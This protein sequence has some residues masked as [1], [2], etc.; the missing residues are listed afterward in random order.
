[1]ASSGFYG[2]VYISRS[3]L[4]PDFLLL[5]V[6]RHFELLDYVDCVPTVWNMVMLSRS[7]TK[8]KTAHKMW[9][10]LFSLCTHIHTK[11]TCP[12]PQSG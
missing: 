6:L 11:Q 10:E 5:R 9:C 8:W 3:I 1:M 4:T 7:G 2:E 12:F